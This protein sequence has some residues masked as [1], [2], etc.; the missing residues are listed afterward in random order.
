MGKQSQVFGPRHPRLGG[1][2]WRPVVV[3]VFRFHP[4]PRPVEHLYSARGRQGAI[5]LRT[6]RGQLRRL[7]HLTR[8]YI[9]LL[10]PHRRGRASILFA[11]I[12][13]SR[14]LCAESAYPSEQP[15]R[16][17]WNSAKIW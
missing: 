7:E 1:S 14:I 12:R 15:S 10:S 13:A 2:A 11:P 3:Y 6:F 4:P 5:Y 16:F 9:S 17:A 8:G